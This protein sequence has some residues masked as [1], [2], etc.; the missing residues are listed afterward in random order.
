MDSR[1]LSSLPAFIVPYA[2]LTRMVHLPVGTVIPYFPVLIAILHV[3]A[4]AHLDPSHILTCCLKWLVLSSLYSAYGC[5]VDDIADK[6]LDSKVE[7]CQNR[8]LVR[9]A[10]SMTA[11]CIF[12][13][14]IMAFN[15]NV[16]LSFFPSQPA[17]HVPI[18]II[19]PVI[20]PFLKRF[21]HYALLYLALLYTVTAFNASRTV[22]FDIWTNAAPNAPAVRLSALALNAAVFVANL[23]VETIY[24]HADLADDLKAGIKTVAVRIRGFA[25]PV[26]YTL[27]LLYPVLLVATGVTAEFGKYYFSGAACSAA[28]LFTLVARVDLAVPRMC[29]VY[30][31]IGN[32]GVMTLLAG[33]L[34]AEFRFAV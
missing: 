15:T 5:V 12:A 26:L 2:E 24:H 33:A 9:G 27:A 8:P 30:F 19:C 4:I 3:A 14:T 11:A 25:K 18:T 20:Y 28:L 29:E 13:T 32:I 31:F 23:T 1:V 16:T 6:D 21:T 17:I 10:I 7:R 22:G 34:F